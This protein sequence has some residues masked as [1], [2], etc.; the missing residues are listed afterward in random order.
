MSIQAKP[1]YKSLT[2]KVKYKASR[3]DAPIWCRTQLL[4]WHA[5]ETLAGAEG[6]N[7]TFHPRQ[8]HQTEDDRWSFRRVQLQMKTNQQTNCKPHLEWSEA[9]NK[10]S[11]FTV[12]YLLFKHVKC[13][14][15]DHDKM[16]GFFVWIQLQQTNQG[17]AWL[18]FCVS[19]KCAFSL[20]S[21]PTTINSRLASLKL[22][23]FFVWFWR[24]LGSVASGP[25]VVLCSRLKP[26]CTFLCTGI[27]FS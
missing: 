8:I 27:I 6:C 22:I 25:S 13:N 23:R 3:R 20:T 1:L 16:L 14:K 5:L 18:K 21:R 15:N 10:I 17:S 11:F 7:W 12:S 26:L 19:I 2:S 4:V 24:T 9:H